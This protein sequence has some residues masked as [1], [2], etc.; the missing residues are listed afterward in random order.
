MISGSKMFSSDLKMLY[1]QA[2]PG[3]TEGVALT[4]IKE[5]LSSVLYDRV[6]KLGLIWVLNVFLVFKALHG[7]WIVFFG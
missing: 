3:F 7:P 5:R 6:E 2:P 4:Q 1:S